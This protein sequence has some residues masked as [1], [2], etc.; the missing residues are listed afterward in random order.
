MSNKPLPARLHP[1]EN[2]LRGILIVIG[3]A[4]MTFGAMWW[5]H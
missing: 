2:S 4:A 1:N 3:L 5:L